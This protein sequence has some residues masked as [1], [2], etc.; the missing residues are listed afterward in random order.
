MRISSDASGTE[1][2][3]NEVQGRS[4]LTDAAHQF[5]AMLLQ[6][7]LKPLQTEDGG[8][9]EEKFDGASDTITSFGTE[10]V[11]KAISE[12]GGLGIA[13]QVIRQVSA[14]HEKLK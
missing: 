14:E 12:S 6:E 7:L 3:S 4:K 8:W 11:A 9:G 10:A 13:R 5:E 1:L 2:T